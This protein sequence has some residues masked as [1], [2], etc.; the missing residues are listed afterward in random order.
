MASKNN[1]CKG[2]K[3]QGD[4]KHGCQWQVSYLNALTGLHKQ[5][6]II[7]YQWNLE[8]WKRLKNQSESVFMECTRLESENAPLKYATSA[9]FQ[10][11]KNNK[12]DSKRCKI[13]KHMLC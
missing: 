10:K 5:F 4:N 7:Y 1:S 9:N 13:G 12:F 6:L 3:S 11:G 2:E 8:R